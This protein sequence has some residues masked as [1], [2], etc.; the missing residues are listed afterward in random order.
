M[1]HS[2]TSSFE[3]VIDEPSRAPGGPFWLSRE[4][5]IL[6]GCDSLREAV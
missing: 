2:F 6:Y 1:R 3:L 5:Y 4:E